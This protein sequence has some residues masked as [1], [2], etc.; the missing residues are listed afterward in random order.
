MVIALASNKEWYRY[1]VVNLYSLLKTTKNI[2]KIYFILETYDINE[3]PKLKEVLEKYPV[4]YEIIE[5]NTIFDTLVDHG[6][7]NR[8]TIYTNFCFARLALPYLVKE[9]KILYIDSDAIVIR[10][11][12]NVWRINI[13]DYYVAGCK[14]YGVLRDD[15]YERLNI[16]GKYINSG[17]IILNLKKI[18][19]DGI[20]NQWFKIINEQYLKYP[21]QDALNL[22]CQHNEL[23]IPSM[24]NYAHNVTKDV[25]IKDYIKVFHYAGPKI[26]WVVDKLYA[27]LW[28]T[29]EDEFLDIFGE[30]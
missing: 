26:Q 9:D 18:R 1:L 15:T 8:D 25:M 12:S 16:T 6:N 23:Y 29:V 3:V 13:D 30:F 5:F 19:E 22:V 20:H 27:E 10:D 24:Y 7:I 28:Y 21:D 2:K 4:E 14:D 11:I 17:F